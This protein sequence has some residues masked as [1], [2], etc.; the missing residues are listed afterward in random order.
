M[1]I[2]V[3]QSLEFSEEDGKQFIELLRHASQSVNPASE[4]YAEPL[5]NLLSRAKVV[6]TTEIKD[7]VLDCGNAQN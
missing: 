2:T 3:A 6:S 5:S 7:F 1:I 4:T